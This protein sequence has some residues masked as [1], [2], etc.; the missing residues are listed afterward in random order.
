MRNSTSK[1]S[2][3]AA[4]T[5][6]CVVSLVLGL[7]S[8]V[9]TG[10]FSVACAG[11]NA[12][13]PDVKTESA[14]STSVP[15]APETPPSA[16]P[17]AGQTSSDLS[18]ACAIETHTVMMYQGRMIETVTAHGQMYT[19]E[20][21]GTPWT[22]NGFDLTSVGYY[23]SG[24]CAGKAAGQC[25]FDTRTYARIDD[26]LIEFVTAYGKYWSFKNAA[27]TPGGQGIDLSTI[28]RYSQICALRGGQPCTFDTRAFVVLDKKLT[29]TITAY[30]K[31]FNYDESGKAWK[32]NG[33]DL[34]AVPRYANGPCK[35]QS[36]GTCKFD[37]R[38]FGLSDGKVVEIITAGGN[39]YRY[40]AAGSNAFDEIQPSSVPITSVSAWASGPCK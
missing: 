4:G 20:A 37:T 19:F 40:A 24:P 22:T 8:L 3:H 26:E 28:G 21:N 29:E 33:G 25:E 10:A 13:T 9:L 36:A 30:G 15:G 34:T 1:R 18:P 23:A 6:R 39:I 5:G 12:M 38:T 35:G 16:A 11:D 17:D 31:H 7:G 27:A 32:D 2:Q 14:D